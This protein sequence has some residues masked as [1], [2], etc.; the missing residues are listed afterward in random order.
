M[1]SLKNFALSS[2]LGLAALCLLAPSAALAQ[3]GQPPAPAQVD[4]RQVLRALL[5]EVHQ[6][7]LALQQASL[8]GYRAQIAVERLR[9]QQERVERLSREL[10]DYRNQIAE[11]KSHQSRLGEMLKELETQLNRE[12][13]LV[14]R[15]EIDS[16]YKMLKFEMDQQAQREQRQREREAQLQAQLQAEQSKLGELNDRL[17]ALEREIEGQQNADKPPSGGKQP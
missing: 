13:D 4:E 17:D 2:A 6:L 7:R 15:V 16:Q 5:N 9:L 1:R 12:A 8:S 11:L 10:E 3:D 14:R